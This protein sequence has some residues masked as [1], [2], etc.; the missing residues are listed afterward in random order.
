MDKLVGQ[1]P[2]DTFIL[3]VES[4]RNEQKILQ[5]KSR[6]RE[7]QERLSLA[8]IRRLETAE[9]RRKVCE[10][11]FW[12]LAK[13]YLKLENQFLAR[14]SNDKQKVQELEKIILAKT[15]R[16]LWWKLPLIVII[17]L[18]I[19][20]I[21]WAFLVDA[22]RKNSLEFPSYKFVVLHKWYKSNF[23]Q[24]PLVQH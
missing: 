11:A 16:G 1:N 4:M 14:L 22:L 13:K 2:R 24:I 7:R 17:S 8:E 9:K 21:G 23:G 15:K 19:P 18:V 12:V 5:A 3:E 6:E 10:Y 20:I